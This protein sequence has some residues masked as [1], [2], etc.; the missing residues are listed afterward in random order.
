MLIDHPEVGREMLAQEGVYA[1]HEGADEIF[2]GLA[3]AMDEYAAAYSEIAD[4]AWEEEF[5]E[6]PTRLKT[7]KAAH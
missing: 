1:T 5:K 4:P 6:H 3:T 2:T 7:I